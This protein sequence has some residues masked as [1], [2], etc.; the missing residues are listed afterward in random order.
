MLNEALTKDAYKELSQTVLGQKNFYESFP[1]ECKNKYDFVTAAGLIN[2]HHFDEHIF[3][4][5]LLSLK[6]G[7]YMIF[8]ARFSYI[9]DY[10]YTSKLSELEIHQ[11][12]KFIKSEEFFKYD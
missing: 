6:N 1:V 7:G 2:N 9:G 3:E 5:M 11:R 12:V 4:Q 8:A 10:W